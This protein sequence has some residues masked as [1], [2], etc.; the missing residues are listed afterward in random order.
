[1]FN[2]KNLIFFRTRSMVENSC[3]LYHH[4][5][6]KIVNVKVN[7]AF[8]D[9]NERIL[10]FDGRNHS[11]LYAAFYSFRSN[12]LYIFKIDINTIDLEYSDSYKWTF[13]DEIDFVYGIVYVID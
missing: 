8:K 4:K 11:I 5:E 10:C 2:E 13:V 7:K 1:M 9:L 12:K 3:K 6:N